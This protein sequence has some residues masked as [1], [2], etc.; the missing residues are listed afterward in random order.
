MYP[1]AMQAQPQTVTEVYSKMW[2]SKPGLKKGWLGPTINVLGIR[3][4]PTVKM[5]FIHL[6][7]FLLIP[8]CQGNSLL[9]FGFPMWTSHC[10][11]QYKWIFF[12]A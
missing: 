12:L 3:Y 9:E 5:N 2:L 8:D 10:V 4:F 6:K 1:T 7:L 11:L